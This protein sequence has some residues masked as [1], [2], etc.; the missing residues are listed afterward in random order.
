MELASNLLGDYQ[1][2]NLALAIYSSE[3]FN[4]RYGLGITTRSIQ[5]ALKSLFLP[6]RF[7]IV[8]KKPVKI[9]DTAHNVHA[10]S[11]L[12]RNL[13]IF[14][15]GRRINFLIGMLKDKRP[16]ECIK[17]IKEISD[18]I[19]LVNVPNKRS[20]NASR[21]SKTL[22]DPDIR[23]I[24]DGDIEKIVNSKKPLIITGS[25]YLIGHLFDKHMQYALRN[26]RITLQI[27]KEVVR[28]CQ[29]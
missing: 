22:N 1:M 8:S 6:G 18:T 28:L 3:I 19:Y 29:K 26:G 2:R 24:S 4:E 11:N 10:I 23:F 14:L 27:R 13:K 7:Q 25:T 12:V 16:R 5:N 20:F 17:I 21:L 15:K 9:I